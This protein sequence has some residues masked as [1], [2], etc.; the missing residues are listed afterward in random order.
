MSE[1]RMKNVRLTIGGVEISHGYGPSGA[2]FCES[3]MA[4]TVVLSTEDAAQMD[5]LF[6]E[7]QEALGSPQKEAAILARV[8]ANRRWDERARFSKEYWV[9]RDMRSDYSDYTRGEYRASLLAHDIENFL[10]LGSTR[11]T[12][13]KRLLGFLDDFTRP[14]TPQQLRKKAARLR[15]KGRKV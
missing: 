9:H 10:S 3:T 11:L 7:Q 6:Q 12:L 8:A 1:Y 5:K 15:K 4:A 14:R 13:P 2:V